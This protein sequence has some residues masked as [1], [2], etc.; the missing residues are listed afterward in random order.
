MN[1]RHCQRVIDRPWRSAATSTAMVGLILGVVLMGSLGTAPA[2]AESS[3]ARYTAALQALERGDYARG[4]KNYYKFLVIEDPLL[5]LACRQADLAKAREWLHAQGVTKLGRS[6]GELHLG[7]CARIL[8]SWTEAD[9]RLATLRKAHPKSM[10][11]MFLQ[12]EFWM[13]EDR[14]RDA[15]PLFSSLKKDSRGKQ[16]V[17]L[18]D[19]IVKRHGVDLEAEADRQT[20]LREAMRHLDLLEYADAEKCLRKI[21]VRYPDELEAPRALIDMLLETQRAD[22]ADRVLADWQAKHGISPLLPIQEAH[23]HYLRG[24]FVEAAPLLAKAMEGE[25]DNVYALS[26]LAEAEF[27]MQQFAS[28]TV[29]FGRL[30]VGDP[31]NLGFLLRW[32]ACVEMQGD[33][34]RA[35][36]EFDAVLASKPDNALLRYERARLAD[37]QQFFAEAIRLYRDIVDAGGPYRDV[38]ESNLAALEAK[39]G[40]GNITGL[41]QTAAGAV[42]AANS[43]TG[44]SG[45]GSAAGS[46]GPSAGDMGQGSALTV[47]QTPVPPAVTLA[48]PPKPVGRVGPPAIK[49]SADDLKRGQKD[50]MGHLSKMY[51]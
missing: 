18:V 7:L 17:P 45:A 39:L 49:P 30:R 32:L 8:V 48:P 26:M 31:N 41:G 24:R 5:S 6:M 28:A 42:G 15:A 3:S 4:V 38:A 40:K 34:V 19:L 2:A 22:D 35:M 9:E 36:A 47:G 33:G 21:M 27:Q 46:V 10:L 44:T 11:L 14:G 12:G 16:F 13:Q 1:P 29:S 23:L 37:R 20:M 51:E 50:L 25:D 43:P